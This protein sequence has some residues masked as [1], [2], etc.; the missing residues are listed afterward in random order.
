[1]GNYPTF[2][3]HLHWTCGNHPDLGEHTLRSQPRIGEA[4]W[5]P[6]EGFSYLVRVK[7]V[8]HVAETEE[9]FP[10]LE[11]W[12]ALEARER[13]DTEED[14]EEISLVNVNEDGTLDYT[15]CARCHGH[16]F[17]EV[18]SEYPNNTTPLNEETVK[19]I[20]RDRE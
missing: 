1:M 18:N 6:L 14:E 2:Y 16:E 8:I 13:T 9:E 3:C 15:R 17:E 5:V 7:D 4:I 20:L 12:V 11:V 19:R 10:Y